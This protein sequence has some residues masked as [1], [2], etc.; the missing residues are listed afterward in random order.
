MN[1]LTESEMSDVLNVDDDIISVVADMVCKKIQGN[2]VFAKR[3]PDEM[4]RNGIL[5]FFHRKY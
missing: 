3:V 4:G 2:V 5:T 1:H